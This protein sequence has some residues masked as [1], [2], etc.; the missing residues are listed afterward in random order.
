MT[1]SPAMTLGAY[2]FEAANPGK[3]G[4]FWSQLTGGATSAGGDSVYIAPAGE[5]GFGVFMQPL[6]GA[7]PDR[8][9]SHLDLTVPWGAR[10]S[11]VERAEALGANVEW[12]VLDEYPHVQWT[13]LSDP[14]GNLFCIAEHPPTS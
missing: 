3:L 1:S 14:E 12:H 9:F 10:A 8:Q 11:E 6:R 13:T 5:H 2:N 4:Q 7:R